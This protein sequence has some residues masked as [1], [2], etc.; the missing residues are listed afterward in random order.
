MSLLLLLLAGCA[1]DHTLLDVPV[2]VASGSAEVV[3]DDG[4]EITLTTASLTVGGLRLEH[5]PETAARRWPR[6][7][8]TAYAHPGHDFSGEVG[9]ELVGTWV[10]DLLAGPTELGVASI[11]DGD[12]ATGRLTLPADGEVHLEGVCADDGDRPFRFDLVPD[13]DVTGIP[14]VVTLDADTSPE[15]L[16]LSVD[17]GHALSFVDWSTA[18][19]GDG[20]LTLDDGLLANTV[21]F[22]VVATPTYA[23]S[24]ED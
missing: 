6:L 10:V 11:Y 16:V 1:T 8:S 5:P 23:L 21:L 20:V 22:G 4:V 19:D 15:A 14:F 3:T 9:G 7:I 2:R 13:Q 18:D 12:Y 17:L 24:L